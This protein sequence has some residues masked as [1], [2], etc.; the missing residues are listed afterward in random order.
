MAKPPCHAT[1]SPTTDEEVMKQTLAIMEQRNIIGLTSGP[2]IAEWVQAAPKR[3]IPSLG[4]DGGPRAPTVA[5]M[6][7]WFAAK[8]FAALGEVTVQYGGM[9]P[10]DPSLRAY[11]ALAEEMEVPVGIHIGTGPV[12]APYLAPFGRYRARLHSPLLLEEV[13]IRHPKL[14][15]FI[16]HAGWPMLDDLLAVLWAHPHV[17]VDLGAIDW[18]L[19]RP[20]FH[21]YLQRIVEAGF[22]KRVLFG[23]DQMIWPETINLAIESVES[24]AFLTAEQKRDILYN[25]AARF[26]RLSE[27]E[28]ARHRGR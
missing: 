3:I 26:L 9:E 15:V 27:Q 20:E 19:P 7:E 16:M 28:Q 24:A 25:N 22:G 10:D 18:A 1:W 11:W 13:L 5:S 23:S 4:F 6:R 8:R 21:R 2:R 17:H 14:R 12:G